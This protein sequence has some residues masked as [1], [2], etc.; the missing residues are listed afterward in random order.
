MVKCHPSRTDL[1]GIIFV[2]H[3]AINI[4]GSA[5]VVTP[6]KTGVQSFSNYPKTRDSDSRRNDGISHLL[7]FCKIINIEKDY[8][9]RRISYAIPGPINT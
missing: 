3:K 1:Y 9:G 2:I 4:D 5:K 6:V 7:A 8:E